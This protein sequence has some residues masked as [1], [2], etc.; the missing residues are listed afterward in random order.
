MTHNFCFLCFC[1]FFVTVLVV[2]L[3][4]SRL[5]SCIYVT[6]AF[7]HVHFNWM[8]ASH[9]W[10]LLSTSLVM[11]SGFHFN[12]YIFEI[13][14]ILFLSRVWTVMKPLIPALNIN[15]YDYSISGSDSYINIL[16]IINIPSLTD[17]HRHSHS[18][19]QSIC[20]VNSFTLF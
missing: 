15:M 9:P 20:N 8:L 6:H 18:I 3:V 13:L 16:K 7:A 19:M 1:C 17:L 11:I 10:T 12:W 2:A 14:I 5:A 4:C